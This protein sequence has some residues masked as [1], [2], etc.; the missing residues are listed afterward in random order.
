MPT[1]KGEEREGKREGRRWEGEMRKGGEGE[2][3]KDDLHPTLFLGPGNRK[4]LCI[5]Q[6]LCHNPQRTLDANELP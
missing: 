3:G 5:C 2:K 4:T 1:S 6:L